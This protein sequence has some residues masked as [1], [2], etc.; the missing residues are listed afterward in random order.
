[1][2][3]LILICTVLIILTQKLQIHAAR[4]LYS[5]SSGRSRPTNLNINPKNAQ[6]NL[7]KKYSQHQYK[8]SHSHEKSPTFVQSRRFHLDQFS[9]D[10]RDLEH[11]S[12]FTA[13]I[14]SSYYS[15]G[16]PNTHLIIS[17]QEACRLTTNV[18]AA[19]S[20]CCSGKCRCIKWSVM[21]KMSCWKKCF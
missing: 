5:Q 8:F 2:I 11:P 14:S 13:P 6:S 3:R 15:Y 20:Q 18:C 7:E 9:R 10:I 12:S 1:M 21:G 4:E 16:G 19:D 17:S